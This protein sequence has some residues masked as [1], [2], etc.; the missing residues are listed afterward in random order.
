MFMKTN[1]DT[2]YDRRKFLTSVTSL[3]GTSMVMGVPGI[4]YAKG[5][6][7]TY[8]VK[9]VLEI[10]LKEI[11]GAPFATTVDQLRSGSMDQEVTGIVTT[12]FPTLEVIEKTAK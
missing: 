7:E 4:T 8:T 9:Q 5:S 2:H 11:P 1:G 6:S 3:V 12:M 10:I